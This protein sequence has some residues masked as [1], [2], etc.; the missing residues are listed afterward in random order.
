[1]L[2]LWSKFHSEY[3]G[4]SCLLWDVDIEERG[5][6]KIRNE[7]IESRRER[8]RERESLLLN[9]IPSR[10]FNNRRQEQ[11]IT[12]TQVCLSHW[13]VFCKDKVGSCWEMDPTPGHDRL[14]EEQEEEEVR[15]VSETGSITRDEDP[16]EPSTV[17]NDIEEVMEEVDIE[18]HGHHGHHGEEL[19]DEAASGH[20]EGLS[21]CLGSHRVVVGMTENYLRLPFGQTSSRCLGFRER[22][23]CGLREFHY[24]TTCCRG[25][26]QRQCDLNCV[27]SY[28][29]A[30]PL[31]LAHW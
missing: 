24:W 6:R 17:D 15:E 30:V 28:R 23:S 3:D 26:R 22:R 8:E 31:L 11:H 27:D 4:P 7:T 14:D 20:D 29:I 9:R 2:I 18:H 12:G 19:G 1:M 13:S 16:T 21:F 10:A 5:K 25:K